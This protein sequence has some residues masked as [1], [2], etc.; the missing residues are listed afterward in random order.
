[1]LNPELKM[2]AMTQYID[3]VL[4]R[5]EGALFPSAFITI[6]CG[7]VSGSP[8]TDLFRYDAETAG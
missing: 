5:C 3:G 6:A 7:A 4:A 1:M 2:P 8:R